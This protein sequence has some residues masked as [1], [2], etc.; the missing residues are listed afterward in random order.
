MEPFGEGLLH[1]GPD[2]FWMALGDG[3]GGDKEYDVDT[4][5]E[6]F[7][8]AQGGRIVYQWHDMHIMSAL[9]ARINGKHVRRSADRLATTAGIPAVGGVPE[10]TMG[11]AQLRC[12]FVAIL[13]IPRRPPQSAPFLLAFSCALIGKPSVAEPSHQKLATG[14]A[15][16]IGMPQ[17]FFCT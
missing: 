17:R 5:A 9:N 11:P 16:V 14:A 12:P 3:W 2:H 6:L 10:P 7:S 13:S 15:F 8:E 4:R 1:A